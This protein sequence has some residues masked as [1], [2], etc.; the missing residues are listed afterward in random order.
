MDYFNKEEFQKLK[1]SPR[2]ASK[3]RATMDRIRTSS[4]KPP[5]N[6]PV[7]YIIT[8]I[9]VILLAAFLI[10]SEFFSPTKQAN[11]VAQINKLLAEK[12]EKIKHL[13]ELYAAKIGELSNANKSINMIRWS[14]IARLD[15][16]SHSFSN[17]ENIYK[18]HS[19]HH[20]QDDW[21]VI[22]DDYFEIELLQ[23]ENAKRVDFYTLRQESDEGINLV[24]TD[25]DP[26]D[27]WIY[28]N[29]DIGKIINKR[30]DRLDP[31]FVLYAEVTLG[32]GSVIRTP[33]LPIYNK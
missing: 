23:Y 17:L 28:I 4:T 30:T 12:D 7:K 5:R 20:I 31:Y 29:S 3:K 14:S 8:S 16:Y 26:T 19:N 9:A 22:Q 27:G 33:K 1:K 15:D 11:E 24:F 25:T 13:E 32:D 10:S 18:V 2:S 6:Y 21:Y